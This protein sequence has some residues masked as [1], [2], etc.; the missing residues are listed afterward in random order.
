MVETFITHAYGE[1]GKGRGGEGRE[2]KGRE[3]GQKEWRRQ[4]GEGEREKKGV[5]GEKELAIL[6]TDLVNRS[7]LIDFWS[8]PGE[9]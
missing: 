9:D 3:G 8:M 6:G 1:E 2:W 4:E 5:E 7:P